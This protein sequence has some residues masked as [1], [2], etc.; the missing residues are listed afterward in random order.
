MLD[1][2]VLAIAAGVDC[3]LVCH[4]LELQHGAIDA[5]AAAVADGK[6]QHARL[7][8]AA[9]RVEKLQRFARPASAI[10]PDKAAAACGTEE[11]RALAREL[12]GGRLVAQ[13]G[14]DPTEWRR[15]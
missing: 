1:A 6:I 10:D 12:N 4:T 9:A 11:H 8:E 5:L 7:G 3:L 14:V 15:V 2:A 13:S